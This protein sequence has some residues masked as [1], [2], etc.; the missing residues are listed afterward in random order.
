[1]EAYE[2]DFDGMCIPGESITP[3][4]TF[5]VGIFQWVPTKSGKGLKK[6]KVVK[7][8]KGLSSDP[9]ELFERAKAQVEKM[10]REMNHRTSYL[11]GQ[12]AKWD[13]Y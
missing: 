11:H 8:L 4:V 12:P 9:N 5:S 2:F 1:M 13:E 7:R 3:N 6:G 10:N